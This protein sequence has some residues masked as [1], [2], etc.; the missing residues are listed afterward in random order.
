MSG[1]KGKRGNGEGTVF[2]L[3]DGRWRAVVD[4]GY[5][6]GT[7][8]RKAATRRTRRE[9]VAWLSEALRARDAGSLVSRTPTVAEWFTTYLDEVAPATVRPLT[10]ANYRRDIHRHVLPSLGRRRLDTLRPEHLTSLYRERQEAGLSIASVRH[11]HAVVRR[12]LNVAVRWGVTPRNVAALVEIGD[13]EQTEIVPLTVEEA[14]ALLAAIRGHRLEARWVVGLSLG[15]RQGEALGLWWEDLDTKAGL[16]RVRRQLV[17]RIGAGESLGFG[18]PKSARSKRTLALP[19]P[20]VELLR[21]HRVTQEAERR[22]AERWQDERL[23]FATSTGRPIAHRNDAR[24]FK[25]ICKLAGI[26]PYRV[27]DQRHTAATL[28]IAQGQHPRM[29]ME[30][31]GHSQISV[32]MNVYGHIMAAQLRGAADA[33]TEALWG[34]DTD[35][36]G[37]E[38]D[39]Q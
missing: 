27:H 19:V 23:V 15:L 4:L 3:P 21:A 10:L 35:D 16:L 17:R 37:S 36:T 2:Q 8:R 13:S 24:E 34:D 6:G 29:I 11:V 22:A 14:R 9:A 26:H 33:V 7:R 30:V 5:V 38:A 1:K 31:L 39:E 12:G 25:T 20:L 32:T 28:L 18:P